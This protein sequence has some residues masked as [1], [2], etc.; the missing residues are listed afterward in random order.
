MH[1]NVFYYL[2]FIHAAYLSLCKHVRLSCVF[3]NKNSGYLLTYNHDAHSLRLS[4]C[5]T[6]IVQACC[7]V[8]TIRQELVKSDVSNNALCVTLNC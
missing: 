2:I 3:R 8:S 5:V 7:A 4:W 6:V 1:V